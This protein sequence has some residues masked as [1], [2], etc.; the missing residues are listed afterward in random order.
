[1]LYGGRV[2]SFF[3]AV[4]VFGVCRSGLCKVKGFLFFFS[5]V[6]VVVGSG[7]RGRE[8]SLKG[9]RRWYVGSEYGGVGFG[10]VF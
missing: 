7:V 1:M 5:L 3:F 6:G 10:G 2:F 4:L 9:G 8:R